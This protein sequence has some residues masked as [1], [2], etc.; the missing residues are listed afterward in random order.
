MW[1]GVVAAQARSGWDGFDKE[2]KPMQRRH[3]LA[4]M[5]ALPLAAH[6]QSGQA[7]SW[8]ERPVHVVVPYPPGGSN[9]ILARILT[10]ALHERLNQVFIVEN[11]AGAGGNVGADL[12]AKAAPDGHTLLLT[13]PG[14]LAINYQ[15][16][17]DMTYDPTKDLV[18]VALV[19][20]VPIV[21]MVNPQV[22]AHSVEELIALAKAQ[23]GKL[24]FGSSGNASTNHLAGELLKA[25]AGIDIVHVPYRGAAPAMADLLAG[26]ISMMF[27]NMPGSIGQIRDGRVRALAV[28]GRHRAMLLPNVPTVA[29][30]GLPGFEA[31]AWFGLAAPGGTPAELVRRIN[32]EVR[33][34]LGNPRV[35]ARLTEAGAVS[36]TLDATAF[37]RFVADERERWGKVVKASGARAD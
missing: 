7:G 11:H 34:A 12:V 24:N 32:T 15:V 27:D 28:A 31:S 10:D 36:T 26:N 14:P 21:L 18:P 25:M 5:A 20:S 4:G 29:E 2:D 16:Y 1:G 33:A 13:A 23:P 3:L 6:A 35:Q 8:P 22:P 37:A 19:A 9:D 17:R 30:S